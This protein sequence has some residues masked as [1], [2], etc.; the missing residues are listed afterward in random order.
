MRRPSSSSANALLMML[1]NLIK[2]SDSFI[3]R[4]FNILLWQV[5]KSGHKKSWIFLDESIQQKVL[6][7]LESD[8]LIGL[9]EQFN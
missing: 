4:V 8:F 9:S 6:L 5:V 2:R 1:L 3:R 7:V